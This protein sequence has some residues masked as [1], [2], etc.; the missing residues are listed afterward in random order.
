MGTNKGAFHPMMRHAYALTI[1]AQRHQS[2]HPP[3]PSPFESQKLKCAVCQ[4]CL[5]FAGYFLSCI[6][7][8]T[9]F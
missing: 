9:R 1:S 3:W 8:Y 7:S 5:C 6:W 4:L 2:C